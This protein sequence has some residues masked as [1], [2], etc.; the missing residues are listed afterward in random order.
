MH[1]R[2]VLPVGAAAITA[3][4]LLMAG[5]SSPSVAVPV[6]QAVDVPLPGCD[7]VACEG[8]ISGAAYELLLPESWNGTLLLWS[9]GYRQADPAPPD[10]EPVSTAP[11]P[12]PRYADGDRETADRLLADGYALAG[13]AFAS[14]GWAVEDGVKAAEDLYAFFSA[15]LAKPQRVY[16]WGESLGGL[17]TQVIAEK[18]P[19]WVSGSLPTCGAVAGAN[20]NLDLAL[21][22][23]Y[24]VKTFFNPGLRLAGYAS[25][26][27]AVANWNASAQAIQAAA[28]TWTTGCR[29]SC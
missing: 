28:G 16:V 14:N 7:Q 3:A 20:L 27:E 2:V 18:H 23:A 11:D 17:I 21:D 29:P 9:H 15:E 1:R 13:S 25:Q 26:A 22:V 12:A 6:A 10:F 5:C 4:M 24:A 19:E 8:E